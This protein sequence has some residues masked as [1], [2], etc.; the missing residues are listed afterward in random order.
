MG[1]RSECILASVQVNKFV[2]VY[3]S[4]TSLLLTPHTAALCRLTGPLLL[5]PQN[6]YYFSL[7]G[8]C[9]ELCF[10]G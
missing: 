5:L 9:S 4:S 8:T 1:S 3:L 7:A 2:A 6:S 10:E